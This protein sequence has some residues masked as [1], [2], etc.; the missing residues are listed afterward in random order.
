MCKFRQFSEVPVLALFFFCFFC[1]GGELNI[2]PALKCV[3]CSKMPNKC[4]PLEAHIGERN[5]SFGYGPFRQKKYPAKWLGQRSHPTEIPNGNHETPQKTICWVVVS[6]IFYFHPENWGRFPFWLIFFRWVETTNQNVFNH[7]LPY[8]GGT[9][10]GVFTCAF[11]IIPQA[12]SYF[13]TS[14]LGPRVPYRTWMS[15]WK[16]GSKVSKWVLNP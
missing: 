8:Y 9:G 15:R 12:V 2:T 14:F 5:P 3:P 6:K 13:T 16:L 4:Q 1:G 10:N 7:S 11:L